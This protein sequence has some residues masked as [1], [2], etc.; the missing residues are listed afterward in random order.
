MLKDKDIENL[1]FLKIRLK[2]KIYYE[3]FLKSLNKLDLFEK[4]DKWCWEY[5][6][7][8]LSSELRVKGKLLY[9]IVLEHAETEELREVCRRKLHEL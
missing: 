7:K 2:S 9:S 4:I 3:D 8:G 5:A 1:I 6:E